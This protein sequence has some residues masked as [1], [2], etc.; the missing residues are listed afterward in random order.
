MKRDYI[1]QVF[2]R[3]NWLQ[4]LGIWFSGEERKGEFKKWQRGKLWIH[5]YHDENCLLH[6]ELKVWDINGDLERHE[7]YKHG[8]MVKRIK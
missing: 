5:H 3:L 4:A 7:I 2:T 8:K 6:G 1:R